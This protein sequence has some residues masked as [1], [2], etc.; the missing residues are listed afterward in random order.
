MIPLSRLVLGIFTA[1]MLGAVA[2]AGPTLDAVKQRDY[3][4]CG[5]NAGL[6]GFSSP[7]DKGAWTGIDV[8]VCRAVAT[9][10]LG[11]ASKVRFTPLTAKERFTALQSGEIDL[12]SRNTTW[13]LS[14][15]AAL[16]VHFTGVTY[17]DGQGFLVNKRLG[18]HSAKELDGASVCVQAGTTSELNLA[19]Y[20]RANGMRYSPVVYEKAEQNAAAYDAGRCDVL[21]S[22]QSQLYAL[23]IKLKHPEQHEVLPE[24]IS[25]EPLGPLVRQDDNEWFNVVKWSL[26]AMVDAEDLGLSSGNV[27]EAR[28]KSKSPAV[29]RFLGLEGDKG[30]DLKLDDAWAYRIVKQVGNYGEVFDRNLGGHSPLKIARGLNAL[31]SAGGLQYAPPIR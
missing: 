7:D 18:V 28:A 17:Y 2:Q 24:V 19:D 12:L 21:T 6:P 3:V 20:F 10:V 14:R 11:S 1:A 13:T 9:A 27:D 22:D 8:D 15:D 26:F 23:R 4:R 31:W 25:K 16:G 30:R 5:V 29:R